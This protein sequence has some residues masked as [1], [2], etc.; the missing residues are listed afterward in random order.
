MGVRES[1]RTAV[2][3]WALATAVAAWALIVVGG[4][5][6]ATRSG[7]GCGEHWPLCHGEAVPSIWTREVALEY[8]HRVVAGVVALLTAVTAWR[9][10]RDAAAR[11]PAL[12]ALG[13]VLIQS[14]LGAWTVIAGLSVP[15][16]TLHLATAQ[17][18]FVTL[19]VAWVRAA[20]A[21]GRRPAPAAGAS[22]ASDRG[23]PG[24]GAA[25]RVGRL[26]LL[27][28]G[29]GYLTVV[30]GG[31]V[32]LSGA[33]LGCGLSFPLCWGRVVPDLSRP[34]GPLAL[35]HWLHRLAAFALAGHVL[36]L[37][38]RSRRG[39]IPAA[40]RRLAWLAVGL[41][42]LQLTL[43]VATV[44][45][46]LAPALSVAHLANGTALLGLLA[47]LAVRLGPAAGREVPGAPRLVAAEGTAG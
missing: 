13:L 26:A 21:D 15:I 1:A 47:S 41:V 20:G 22:E 40:E 25:G 24:P 14:L 6:S 18:Y 12:A 43:G 11:G 29:L 44:W 9:A 19:V 42:A 46:R 37:A 31:Y 32:K 27:S 45:T 5:V 38:L 34:D 16:S 7:M 36:A 33:G 17:L 4:V 28:L 8:G 10:R 2:R 30:L 35:A 3:G 39:G 23:E